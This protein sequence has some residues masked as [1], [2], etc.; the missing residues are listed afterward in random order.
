MNFENRFSAFKRIVILMFVGFIS[1]GITFILMATL[2]SNEGVSG[3]LNKYQKFFIDDPVGVLANNILFFIFVF[4]PANYIIYVTFL[5]ILIKYF[6]KKQLPDINDYHKPV[7]IKQ[8]L[9][10][11][12]ILIVMFGFLP[13]FITIFSMESKVEKSVNTFFLLYTSAAMCPYFYLV[14]V[15]SNTSDVPV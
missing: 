3:F 5:E 9:G 13:F 11:F 15:D 12:T 8:L 2:F 6:G 4:F 14:R 10:I 7:N 1:F